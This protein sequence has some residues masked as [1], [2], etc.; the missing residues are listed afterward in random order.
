MKKLLFLMGFCALMAQSAFAQTTTS[1][2]QD[3]NYPTFS[4]FHAPEAKR[5]K[6]LIK[7][8]QEKQRQVLLQK[9]CG[10][11]S[12]QTKALE[13]A[14]AIT[15]KFPEFLSEQDMQYVRGLD[16]KK[17][18]ANRDLFV[19]ENQV[20]MDK[21]AASYQANVL[22]KISKKQWCSSELMAEADVQTELMFET[23]AVEHRLRWLGRY[24]AYLDKMPER[25]AQILKI[26]VAGVAQ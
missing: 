5:M 2:A 15:Y 24:R 7:Y 14:L 20:S 11:A 25:N 19:L 12:E 8:N 26:T 16:L 22:A 6:A 21:D 23:I 17:P 9:W 4:K 18:S 3:P 10:H 13:D 1:P